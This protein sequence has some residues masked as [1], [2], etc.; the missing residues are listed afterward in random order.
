MLL[1]SCQERCFESFKSGQSIVMTGQA[2]CGKSYLIRIMNDF[3]LS[4]KKNI[5]ITALTGAAAALI[6]GLTLHGWAGIGLGA[7]SSDEIY[8]HMRKFRK[9]H[10]QTWYE[11]DI[12][13]IDEISMMGAELFNKLNALAQ[14][15]R[16]NNIFFGGIQV[17]L[18]GDFAQLKPVSKDS[19]AKF[20]FESAAWQNM[21]TFYL[22]KIMRQS[23]PVFQ[24]ILSSVRMGELK[25][26]H[27]SI[28]NSRI[29]KDESEA[30]LFIEMPDGSRQIIKGTMLYPKKKDVNQ[31]NQVKLEQLI[32]TGVKAQIYKSKDLVVDTK[33][34]INQEANA[35]QIEILNKCCNAQDELH[36]AIGA[37]VMLIKNLDAAGGLVNGSRGIVIDF[38]NDEF[39]LPVVMFDNGHQQPMAIESFEI[40]S[41]RFKIVRHQVPLILAWALTIHKCQGATIT[42]VI[43]DLT[44]VFE[45]AQVYVTLSRACSLEGLFIIGI[46]YSKIKCN[47][48]VKKYYTDLLKTN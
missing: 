10:M 29:I 28:L 44:E 4:N 5:A 24:D 2:G 7:G 20:C 48:R 23:D 18:C 47:P 30:D 17:V 31:T 43:T 15:I 11:L 32:A 22:D 42:N 14:L 37:Q 35:S 12:L 26:E 13:I 25:P 36:L 3:S 8:Q 27:K 16:R 46:N 41:G 45:E 34:K 6:G 39:H 19:N 40:E 38:T 1:T 33:N 21:T 9:Q